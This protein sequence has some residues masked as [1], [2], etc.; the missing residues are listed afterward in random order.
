MRFQRKSNPIILGENKST[1]LILR[2]HYSQA[3]ILNR[4][5]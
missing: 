4:V 2:Y 3:T 5:G 1:V